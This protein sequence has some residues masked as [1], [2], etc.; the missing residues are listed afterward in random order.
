MAESARECCTG[1]ALFVFNGI[2]LLCGVVL[3]VYSL[4]LGPLCAFF[5][6]SHSLMALCSRSA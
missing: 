4:F 2:D 1:S 3:T 5:V 6:S